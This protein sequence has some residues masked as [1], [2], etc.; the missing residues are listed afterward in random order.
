[1]FYLNDLEPGHCFLSIVVSSQRGSVAA[2]I[3]PNSSVHFEVIY[4]MHVVC[5]A[6]CINVLFV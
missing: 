2:V 3:G 5:F 6:V 1:M 4:M